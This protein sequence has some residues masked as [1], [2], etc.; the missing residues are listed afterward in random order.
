MPFSQSHADVA[1]NFFENLL[2]HTADQWYG[3]PFLLAPWEGEALEAVFGTL[4]PEGLRQIETVYLEVPKK[5]GK[6]EFAAGIILL[7]LMLD[8]NPGC[9]VYGAAA[10]QRQALNV[11]RAACKMV[12]QSPYLSKKLRLVRSTHRIVKRSDPESFYAAV[13][14]DGDLSDGVNPS[15]TVA[16]EIHRW[17]TRKQLENW[18]VLT[19]GGITRKQTLN[20]AITTAGVR[21]ESPLAWRLHEKT[22]RIAL[23]L[24]EDPT[25]YGRIYGASKEDDH[26]DPKT[27]IKANPS[28]VENGGFLELDKIRKVYESTLS[29]PEKLISFKRY[30][31]NIWDE[32]RNRC[33]DLAKWDACVKTFEARPLLEKQPEDKVRPLHRDVLAHFIGRRCWAGVDMSITTDFTAVVFVFD[34]EAGGFEVLPFFWLPE[35]KVKVR[36]RR[37]HMPYSKWVK[38]GWLEVSPGPV[39]DVREMRERLEWGNR[40]FELKSIIF[41]PREARQISSPMTDE[42]YTCVHLQ[43]GIAHLSEPSKKFLECVETATL[44]H[45]GHPI[46]RFNALSLSAKERDGLIMFEKPDRMRETVRID[47]IAATANALSQAIVYAEPPPPVIE[48]WG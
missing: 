42:G 35:E 34:T 39:I 37:D 48:V 32:A 12:E 4:T 33:I 30:Y 27:W 47:G 9:Q 36:E 3:H 25:F 7:A 18:D 10:A 41:D 26:S 23:G 46:Y 20:I 15:V 31:L 28:L 5:A 13:A 8:P 43:Q 16:D 6:T 11:Y 17:K 21:S 19:L 14:A 1:C 40:M 22:E 29:E 44:H 2:C 45:G 38:E 24:A